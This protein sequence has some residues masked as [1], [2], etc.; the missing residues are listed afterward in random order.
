VSCAF[1]SILLLTSDLSAAL[2]VNTVDALETVIDRTNADPNANRTIL[3][4][5]LAFEIVRSP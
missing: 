3:I 2:T 5:A 1:L 4:S